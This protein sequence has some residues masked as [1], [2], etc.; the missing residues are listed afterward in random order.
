MARDF[1]DFVARTQCLEPLTLSLLVSRICITNHTDHTLTT[2]DLAVS[3]DLFYRC[4]Y[5]HLPTPK[6]VPLLTNAARTSI[7]L[8]IGFLHH[9]VVLVRHHV[10]LHLRH[11]VHDHYHDDQQRGTTQI[12][13]HVP[14]HD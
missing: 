3:A 4:S 13:G 9:R 14:R 1:N 10:T 7:I 6:Q 11:E 8:Q 2:N 12:E 5:F